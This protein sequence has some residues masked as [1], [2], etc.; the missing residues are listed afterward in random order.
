MSHVT[1]LT[2]QSWQGYSGHLILR[3]KRGGLSGIV[4]EIDRV[5]EKDR[6]RENDDRKKK[7]EIGTESEK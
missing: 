5:G 2:N 4:E 3:E 1:D 6:D 7:V